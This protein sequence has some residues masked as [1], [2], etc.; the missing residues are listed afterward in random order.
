MGDRGSDCPGGEPFPP[1]APQ[2]ER[3]SVAAARRRSR[4]PLATG[5]RCAG[6]QP[7]T[8]PGRDHGRGK[9]LRVDDAIPWPDD[10]LLLATDAG[11]RAYSP[12]ARKL[13]RVDLPEPPQPATTLVRD[14]LGRLWM[15]GGTIWTARISSRGLWLGEPGAKTPEAFDRVPW[16]GRNE[17]YAIAPDPQH[18]DGVIVALGWQ[19]SRSSGQG[20][21]PDCG[22]RW[23]DEAGFSSWQFLATGETRMKHG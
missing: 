7:P 9:A 23:S 1:E 4:Q 21:S 17:V 5:A 13:S 20:K 16:V 10:S 11:L 2:H 12:D 8:D 6:G 19:A 18:A 14:G 22:G 15:G 3:S